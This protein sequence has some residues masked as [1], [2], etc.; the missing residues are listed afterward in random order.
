MHHIVGDGWS[1][2]VLVKEVAAL[3]E[4]FAAGKSSPLPELP[5]QYA[6]FAVGPREWLQGPVLDKQLNYWREQLAGAPSTLELPSD[7]ARPFAP[8]FRGAHLPLR[9][10]ARLLNELKELGQREGTTL[11]MT[12]LAVWQTLLS[13]YSGQ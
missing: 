3:Y 6:D 4:A 9:I 1:M 7:Y 10:P 12:L 8:S 13:R 2:D 5:I 11:F